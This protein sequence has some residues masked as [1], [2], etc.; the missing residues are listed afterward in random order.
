MRSRRPSRFEARPPTVTE[1]LAT[2]VR[3]PDAC[4]ALSS[5]ER[6]LDRELK[7]GRFNSARAGEVFRS[8][9]DRAVKLAIDRRDAQSIADEPRMAI[10]KKLTDD[11]LSKRGAR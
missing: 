11:F 2:L 4:S 3:S 6:L 7:R 10:A 8:A 9:T 5:A 1:L